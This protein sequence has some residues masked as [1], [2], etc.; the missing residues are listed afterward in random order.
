M[1]GDEDSDVEDGDE[2]PL[3]A[4]RLGR[5]SDMPDATFANRRPPH[6][7]PERKFAPRHAVNDFAICGRYAVTATIH[8]RIW[9][10]YSGES[11]CTIMLHGDTKVTAVAFVYP[12]CS[13][14]SMSGQPRTVWAGTKDGSLFEVDIVAQ[15]ITE[16]RSN[17]HSHAIVGIFQTPE[18]IVTTVD[19]AGKVQIWDCSQ[20]A[21]QA[22]TNRT[23]SLASLPRTQR[24]SDKHSFVQA[25][26]TQLWSSQGPARHH[27]HPTLSSTPSSALRS[28]SIR[29][30]DVGPRSNFPQ[31]QRPVYLPE[32]AGSVGAVSAGAAIPCQPNLVYLAHESGHVSIWEK[33]TLA[34]ISVVRV[35][36]FA[37]M[38]LEGVVDKL[39]AGNREGL[40]HI[41]DT[42]TTPWRVVKAWKASEEPLIGLKVDLG[43][44]AAVSAVSS[45]TL[46]LCG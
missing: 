14:D 6:I 34:C 4:N 2:D 20:D 13:L 7:S 40:V 21:D 10:T 25:F 23:P 38:A 24:M 17:V 22:H 43:S 11:V 46:R 31:T 27:H 12:S 44:V 35:S 1:G 36:T 15:T 41:Y 19:E 28:P 8:L 18:N 30:Y 5:T 37:I 3:E 16:S 42:S 33:D 45:E 29:V 39:W 32:S 26:G 9:D